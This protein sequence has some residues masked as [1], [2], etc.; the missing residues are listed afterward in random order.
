MT[1][2]MTIE[3]IDPETALKYLDQNIENNR[4]VTNWKVD[5]FAQDMR[6]GK[7]V[8]TSATIKFD[9]ADKLIDGQHRLLAIIDADMTVPMAVSRGEHEGAV[10]V[11]DTGIT[12]S[13]GASLTV[14]GITSS[15][16]APQ[17]AA[18]ANVL[19]AI[20]QGMFRHA[21]SS[22]G[23]QDRM[24]NQQMVDYVRPRVE[25]IAAANHVAKTV[26]R[27]LPLNQ[28]VI[29]AAY[30]VLSRLDRDAAEQFFDLIA[31]GVSEGQ[32]DPILTL[33]RRVTGDK[34]SGRRTMQSTALFMLFR[35]WNAWRDGE[36]FT[37]MQIGSPSGGWSTIPM[38]H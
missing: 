36:K 19:N 15:G 24:T 25:E 6:D 4:K 38:P 30:I 31:N 18:T 34:M 5:Q 26:Y 8:E 27:A 28:S 14:A 10:F 17:I 22:L 13:T 32:G 3:Q 9:E 21:M 23:R 1:I 12:R 16:A 29:A 11:I 7:W 20:E 35:V 2:T 37:K 33:T